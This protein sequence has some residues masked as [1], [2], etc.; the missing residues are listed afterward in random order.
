MGLWL[1]WQLQA[2][3]PFV[4][5]PMLTERSSSVEMSMQRHDILTAKWLIPVNTSSSLQAT[6]LI[7][8]NTYMGRT[9]SSTFF[10]FFSL[11]P[12]SQSSILQIT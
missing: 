12:N 3:P 7:S 6:C 2:L 11:Q 10:F 5:G 8:P 4:L 9:P 1:P